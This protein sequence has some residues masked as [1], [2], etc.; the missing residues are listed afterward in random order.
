MRRWLR[1]ADATPAGSAFSARRRQ[2][3]VLAFTVA[4]LGILAGY[5]IQNRH[6]LAE[7]FAPRPGAFLAIAALIVATLIV[8][9]GTHQVLFGRL[10]IAASAGD[11]FRLVTVSSFTNYLPLSAG[12]VAKAYFLKRVHSL[13]YGTFAV[14]QTRDAGDD[15]RHQRGGGARHSGHRPARLTCSGSWARALPS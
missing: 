13:P 10:G 4:A 9:S 12:M 8:R 3:L 14:G 7:H 11:W 2:R 6:Y 5:L 15:R 1:V